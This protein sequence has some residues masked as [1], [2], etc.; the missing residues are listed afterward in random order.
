MSD[1]RAAAPVLRRFEAALLR[2]A[3]YALHTSHTVDGEPIDAGRR[4]RYVPERGPE[5]VERTTDD[6]DSDAVVDGRTLVGIEQDDYSD[7]AT[8][9]QSKRLM[10][11]LLQHHLS[12]QLLQTRRLVLDLQSLEE[13]AAR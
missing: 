13:G 9:G 5:R 6:G 2:E 3:G 11:F 1:E 7:P 12:G 10:R 8:L 4:Y